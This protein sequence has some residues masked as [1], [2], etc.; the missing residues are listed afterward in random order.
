MWGMCGISSSVFLIILLFT[1]YFLISA[2]LSLWLRKSEFLTFLQTIK[3]LFIRSSNALQ[4][5]FEPPCILA[6]QEGIY[7]KLVFTCQFYLFYNLVKSLVNLSEIFLFL[8]F[9]LKLKHILTILFVLVLDCTEIVNNRLRSDSGWCHF[10]LL[11]SFTIVC[12]VFLELNVN[13]FLSLIIGF[14]RT[15]WVLSRRIWNWALFRAVV[16]LL[17]RLIFTYC[18]CIQ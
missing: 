2:T 8:F 14:V 4:L 7:S 5:T 15:N 11:Y 9:L 13:G 6:L 12:L 10:V 1:E 16:S 3:D 18:L 17:L